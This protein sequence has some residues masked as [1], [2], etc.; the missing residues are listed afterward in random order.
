M[1][2]SNTVQYNIH[3]VIFIGKMSIRHIVSYQVQEGKG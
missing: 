3:S 2:Q 1:L